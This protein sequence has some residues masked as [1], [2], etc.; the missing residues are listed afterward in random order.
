[1]LL[2]LKQYKVLTRGRVDKLEQDVTQATT[3]SLK[4]ALRTYM[5]TVLEKQEEDSFQCTYA[6]DVVEAIGKE[7]LA[8]GQDI[9]TLLKE[10]E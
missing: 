2:V 3:V 6:E 1:M 4:E 9:I 5:N 8:R 10:V 7:L